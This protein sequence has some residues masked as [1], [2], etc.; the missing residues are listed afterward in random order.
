MSKHTPE[1]WV[2]DDGIDCPENMAD[3]ILRNAGEENEWVAVGIEDEE[4][5][6]SSVAYCH[7]N[8][9]QRIVE[10]VNAMA[11]IEDPTAFVAAVRKILEG[12]CEA[13]TDGEAEGVS[14]RS[15]IDHRYLKQVRTA[16]GENNG[17]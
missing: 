7:P 13:F 9:S 4:G 12:A 16:M 2:V 11:G 17:N 3:E 15:E 5:Y 10:C 8:N 14:V 1:P 6:A